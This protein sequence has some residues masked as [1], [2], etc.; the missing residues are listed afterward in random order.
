[1]AQTRSVTH[2]ISNEQN[3]PRAPRLPNW[4]NGCGDRSDADA[5]QA[6]GI[7]AHEAYWARLLAEKKVEFAAAT[8]AG[9]MPRYWAENFFAKDRAAAEALVRDDPAKKSGVL[10]YDLIES[11]E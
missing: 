7:R 6:D 3:R 5:K 9:V 4:F 10:G 2:S 11:K 8:P 1:M